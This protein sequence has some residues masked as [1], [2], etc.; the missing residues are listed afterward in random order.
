MTTQPQFG[1]ARHILLALDE[2]SVPNL[3]TVV[4]MPF[5]R[6]TST[7][8]FSLT[9]N[10]LRATLTGPEDA[11]TEQ[12]LDLSG[13]ARAFGTHALVNDGWLARLHDV[14]GPAPQSHRCAVSSVSEKG[15]S[16]LAAEVVELTTEFRG[17]YEVSVAAGTFETAVVAIGFGPL[18]PLE[19]AVRKHDQLLIRI[20]WPSTGTEVELKELIETPCDQ[21]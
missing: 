18:P 4:L 14:H 12:R 20:R 13:C 5:G 2:N 7:A 11:T 6:L 16:G 21:V 3:A 1:F 15:T 10:E 9:K 8:Q 19:V 17:N